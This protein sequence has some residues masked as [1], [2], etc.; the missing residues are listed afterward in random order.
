MRGRQRSLSFG[1]KG[2]YH[3]Y[4]AEFATGERRKSSADQ[5]LAA[6]KAA[7]EIATT[8]LAPTHP[9]RLGLALNFSVFY[10]EILN[11]PDHACQLAKNAFDDAIA[12]AFRLQPVWRAW[13][14]FP[15]RA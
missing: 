4:L 15:S 10:Y 13:L 1:R 8:D 12:G 5:S 9:I 11:S 7:T 2:D 6:Y 14:I 3:R